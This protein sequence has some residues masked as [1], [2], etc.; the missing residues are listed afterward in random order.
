[1]PIQL[2]MLVTPL[3]G[4]TP[5]GKTDSCIFTWQSGLE[6][7]WPGIVVEAWHID[8]HAKSRRD[9][10]LRLDYSKNNVQHRQQSAMSQGQARGFSQDWGIQ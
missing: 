1:M 2:L 6:N 7:Y 4:P 8:Q 5:K 9:T 10:S 3:H